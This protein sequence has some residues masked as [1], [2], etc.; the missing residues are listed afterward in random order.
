MHIRSIRRAVCLAALVTVAACEDG[1][2]GP[3]QV[4]ELTGTWAS[5]AWDGDAHAYIVNDSLYVSSASEGWQNGP[6]MAVGVGAFH[7]PGQYPLAAGRAQVR[8]ITGGDVI[9]ASYESTQP[10]VL[11]VTEYT[12]GSV[13][14]RVEFTADVQRGYDP[15]GPRASFQGEFRARTSL[16]RLPRRY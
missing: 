11:V 12:G 1:G 9:W 5:Q 16:P 4:G 2:T 3:A 6:Y 14:G 15:A 13:N 8:Y 10:G 7:G